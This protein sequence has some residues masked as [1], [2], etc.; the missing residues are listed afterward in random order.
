MSN[1][2]IQTL[3]LENS[4][5]QNVKELSGGELHRLAVAIASVKDQD[6]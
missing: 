5:T 1:Q 6:F 3:G 2:L 4:V